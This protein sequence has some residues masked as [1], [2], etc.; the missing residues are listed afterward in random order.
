MTR[1]TRDQL[2]GT[3]VCA[4]LDMIAWSEGTSRTASSDDG[5]NVLVGGNLFSDYQNHPNQRIYLPSLHLY[6]TAAG[7]Y[8]FLY[9]TWLAIEEKDRLPDFSPVSQDLGCVLLLQ[10][11]N[12]YSNVTSGMIDVAIPQCNHLWA[13]LPSSPYGQYENT[14]ASLEAAYLR[15]GGVNISAS[16]VRPATNG[17][18]V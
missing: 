9:G 13:S 14:M 2:G 10:Q 7:R 4:F 12:A 15:Y 18:L 3:N 6:S 17:Q 11:A 16:Q 8:Q 5:Y 1:A